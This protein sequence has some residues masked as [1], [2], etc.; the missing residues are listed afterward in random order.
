[1]WAV[2]WEPCPDVEEVDSGSG[3]QPAHRVADWLPFLP[4]LFPT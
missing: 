2:H 1:M 4:K 3:G